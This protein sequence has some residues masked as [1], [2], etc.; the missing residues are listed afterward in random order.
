MGAM[1]AGQQDPQH[2]SFANS[3]STQSQDSR[4]HY[5]LNYFSRVQC[6]SLLLSA[7]LAIRCKESR[8]TIKTNSQG[9]SLLCST[10]AFHSPTKGVDMSH[11]GS[12]SPSDPSHHGQPPPPF[13]R[14]RAHRTPTY[15]TPAIIDRFGKIA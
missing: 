15:E 6:M 8:V 2:R 1:V 10:T 3:V 7:V 12:S 4:S 9:G 13:S 5:S 11:I 14:L